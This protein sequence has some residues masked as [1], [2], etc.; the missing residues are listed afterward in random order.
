MVWA[1]TNSEP[2][3]VGLTNE[4]TLVF[5]NGT[6]KDLRFSL[7]DFD[8]RGKSL[9]TL[10][11]LNGLGAPDTLVTTGA[12]N[13]AQMSYSASGGGAIRHVNSLA[14]TDA[15][16]G[17][18]FFGNRNVSSISFTITRSNTGLGN[19]FDLE[20]GTIASVPEPA[21]ALLSTC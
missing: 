16:T 8:N 1:S 3:S 20:L 4:W 9:E 7:F 11:G 13:N 15:G 18:A 6:V 12:V 19:A 14:T 21:T 10:T 5:S 17:F 2:T